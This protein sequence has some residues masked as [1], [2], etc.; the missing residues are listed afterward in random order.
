MEGKESKEAEVIDEMEIEA[1]LKIVEP[2]KS[3]RFQSWIGILLSQV[4]LFTL[5]LVSSLTPHRT[6]RLLGI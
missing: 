5:R 3:H 2:N 1:A 6:L 4:H